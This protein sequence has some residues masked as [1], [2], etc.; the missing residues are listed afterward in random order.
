MQPSSK[1]QLMTNMRKK[2]MYLKIKVQNK[3]S[4]LYIG[5]HLLT[6]IQGEVIGG[7]HS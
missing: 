4:P 3:N 6:R 1:P 7:P 2:P 5:T